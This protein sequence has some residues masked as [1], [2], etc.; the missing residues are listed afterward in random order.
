MKGKHT[1]KLKITV[2]PSAMCEDEDKIWIFH[3]KLNGL[4]LHYYE[5]GKTEFICKLDEEVDIQES[6]I[7]D[8]LKVG[9]KIYLIPLWGKFIHI[10]DENH[11]QQEIIRIQDDIEYKDKRMFCRA[12]SYKDKIYCIPA[13]YRFVVVINTIDD[14]VQY[15]FD[16]ES[17]INPK[18]ENREIDIN[19]AVISNSGKIYASLRNSNKILELDIESCEMQLIQV[20]DED[21]Y[22]SMVALIEEQLYVTE[23]KNNSN[24]MRIFK[25]PQNKLIAEHNG[26]FILR[27]IRNKLLVDYLD[28]YKMYLLDKEGQILNYKK[29]Q[30]NKIKLGYLYNHGIVSSNEENKYYFS[31]REYSLKKIKESGEIEPSGKTIQLEIDLNM[32]QIRKKYIKENEIHNLKMFIDNLYEE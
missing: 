25:I 11:M 10:Y 7:C 4:F 14:S 16:I 23:Y 30:L 21:S 8:L 22:I 6:M 29:E 5:T 28:E 12:F 20:C 2:W 24:N 17:A 18:E 19:S 13:N 3:G 32:W 31:R 9:H 15:L 26:K 27:T 1:N